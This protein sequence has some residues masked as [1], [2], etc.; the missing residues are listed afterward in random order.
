[1]SKQ[2]ANPIEYL[3]ECCRQGA[4]PSKFDIFNA[5]DEW[6]KTSNALEA[7]NHDTNRWL[8]AEKELSDLKNKISK[9]FSKPVAYGLINSRNDLHD[10]RLWD[11]PHN[12]RNIVVP[13][14]SNDNR[15]TDG[16]IE[17]NI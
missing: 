3:I 1:M 4:M 9:I 12:N 7:C 10:L 16:R 11:N 13:L 8:A 14:Y 15:L 17:Q 5:E 2:H 6:V